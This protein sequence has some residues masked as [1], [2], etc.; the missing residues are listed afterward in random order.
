LESRWI[1]RDLGVRAGLRRVDSLAGTE[2]IGRQN[3]NYAGVV[4]PYF[5]PGSGSVREYRLRR[6]QPELE[7]DFAGNLK[8]RQKYLSLFPS[9][10]RR[11]AIS[12][13][14]TAPPEARASC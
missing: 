5:H 2:I 8:T 1:D 10:T 7:Y 9:K 12:G 3:G 14:S 11:R 4:I 6:D 13:S